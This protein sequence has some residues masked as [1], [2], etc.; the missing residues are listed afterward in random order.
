[1]L[2]EFREF[3]TRGNVLDLAIG[4]ILGASFG[5]IVTS[6]VND[7]VMPPIGLLLGK[8]DFSGLFISLRGEYATLAAARAAGAPV[9]AYGLFLNTTLEFLI[10]AFCVFLMVKGINKLQRKPPPP[11]VP[12][13]PPT[14]DCPY[15]LSTI[16]EAASR[17][18]HCTSD[19][20][21]P[22]PA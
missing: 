10:V 13:G 9:I 21:A 2:K 4:V 15:C 3:A 16:P 20:S 22:A 19:V 8:V 18:A 6:L 11:P 5:K 1:M 14:R 17:C 12:A 7:M